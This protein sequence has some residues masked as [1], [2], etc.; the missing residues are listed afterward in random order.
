MWILL[1]YFQ[2]CNTVQTQFTF[3]SIVSQERGHGLLQCP[4]EDTSQIPEFFLHV[5]WEWVGS[6]LQCRDFAW[7]SWLL[8]SLWYLVLCL[9]LYLS[10]CHVM[11][12]GMCGVKGLLLLFS[13]SAMWVLGIEFGCL[14]MA[15]CTFNSPKPSDGPHFSLFSFFCLIYGFFCW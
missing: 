1:N 9:Y 5:L 13:S 3:I 15:T 11:C 14:D 7:T 12:V 4:L 6:A 2:S 10:V 8:F